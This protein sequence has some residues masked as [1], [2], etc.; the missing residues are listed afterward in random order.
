MEKPPVS[1]G[2]VLFLQGGIDMEEGVEL[3][4]G[5]DTS[6]MS[7]SQL[8]RLFRE[9]DESDLWP[10]CGRFNATDRAIRRICGR[11]TGGMEY[12]YALDAEISRIVNGA[13]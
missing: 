12:A 7:V 6:D 11:Y 9:H 4:Y 10:I 1:A 13:V 3:F 2:G 5:V 8:N